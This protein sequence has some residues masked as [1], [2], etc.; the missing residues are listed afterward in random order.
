MDI[1]RIT[2]VLFDV[3]DQLNR[4]RPKDDQL[5]KSETIILSG[6]GGHLDSLDL[7]NFMLAVEQKLEEEFHASI[8]LT[9]N[10]VLFS[11]DGPLQ[12]VASFAGY[13]AQ[14]LQGPHR[15]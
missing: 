15:D 14:Q 2:R 5:D 6:A 9:D 13:L 1:E 10:G 12:S 11:D 4:Q 7:I 3:I 8:V